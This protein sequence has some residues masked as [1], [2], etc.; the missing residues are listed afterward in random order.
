[1]SSAFNRTPFCTAL[2]PGVDDFSRVRYIILHDMVAVLK[3]LM[4]MAIE[5]EGNLIKYLNV[6]I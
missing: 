2:R 5:E 3:S 6:S 4:D 1:M